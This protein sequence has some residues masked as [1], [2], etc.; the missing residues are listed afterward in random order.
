MNP[1]ERVNAIL[2]RRPVDRIPVDIWYTAEVRQSLVE[3]FGEEDEMRLYEIMGLDK[4]VVCSAVYPETEGRNLWGSRYR[5][6]GAGAAQYNELEQPGLAEYPSVESLKDYPCWPDPGKFD[7]P[8]MAERARS[9]SA[10]FA[11]LGPWISL[12]E[13]YCN[14]RGLEQAMM[15]LVLSP[16]YV[17]AVLDAIE[18]IQTQMIKRFLESAAGHIDMVFISDDMGSQQSLMM[19]LEMWDCFIRDRLKRL[20]D[21]IHGFGVTV[22]YHSDGACE[23][24]IERWIDAG[25]DVL[26]PIQH[27]CP[28]M[29]M[30][31][32]KHKYGGRLIFHGGVDTQDVLPF[33]DTAA[34]RRETQDCLR[35]LGRGKQGYI[36]CSCHNIQAGTPVD[37]ILAMI[38]TVLQ[39]ERYLV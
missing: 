36:C 39:S 21:L 23:P 6:I 12:F 34:V 9:A 37:N 38:D 17:Q 18:D 22:F 20:C 14:L 32:L 19:S 29:D 25:V 1:K 5:T 8:Q 7:Y 16:D 2:N 15:D 35:E 33:G 10:R 11:T 4:I 27:R 28:G 30:A 31:G 26:N 13:N 3:H 24:L